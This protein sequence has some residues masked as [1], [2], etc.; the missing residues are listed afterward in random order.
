MA[1][2]PAWLRDEAYI[3]YVQIARAL[4]VSPRTLR[5]WLKDA[6]VQLYSVRGRP[7][8]P[9]GQEALLLERFWW[10]NFA[11]RRESDLRCL[12][13]VAQRPELVETVCVV[14]RLGR[15]VLQLRGRDDRTEGPSE[16]TSSEGHMSVPRSVR[17]SRSTCRKN[18]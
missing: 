14:T 6:G 17:G 8:L 5:R 12:I 4:G 15:H 2:W 7:V 3:G 1:R 13:K 9:R 18:D 16:E 10:S 11:R